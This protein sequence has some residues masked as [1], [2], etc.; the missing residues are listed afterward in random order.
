MV[1]N[2]PGIVPLYKLG[3]KVKIQAKELKIQTPE[4][5]YKSK[6]IF[7]CQACLSAKSN[8]RVL[9]SDPFFK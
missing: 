1:F 7:F 5:Q 9:A 2:S 6:P 3:T 8:T 4:F